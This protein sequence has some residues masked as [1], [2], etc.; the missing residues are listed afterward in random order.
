MSRP[1]GGLRLGRSEK[2]PRSGNA[3]QVV[4][5]AALES[6]PRTRDEIPDRARDEN[7]AGARG[8]GDARTDMDRDPANRRPVELD[9]AGM[10]AR[11]HRHTEC[12]SV[13]ADREPA[14]DGACW[15][16]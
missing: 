5:P 7:L 8:G 14:A 3:L 9:L 2:L 15:P 1:L 4:T 12:A 10:H 16:I 13:G 11:P 6:Q